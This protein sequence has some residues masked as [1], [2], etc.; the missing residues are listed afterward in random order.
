MCHRELVPFLAFQQPATRFRRAAT[1]LFEK[2]GHV[3][4]EAL[5]ANVHDPFRFH[6]TCARAAL[7]TNDDPVDT[8]KDQFAYRTDEGL[9]REKAYTGIRMLEVGDAREGLC[10]FNRYAK[11]H[12]HRSFVGFVAFVE[13]FLQQGAALGEHL[14]EWN[15]QRSSAA[16]S[17][18]AVAGV[19][20]G[21]TSDQ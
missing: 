11:P 2:E 17:M 13:E 8:L 18:R 10:I 21:V 20:R 3:C 1:P 15:S 14:I 19:F 7:T 16:F 5:V 9:N 12:V 6:G 4:A